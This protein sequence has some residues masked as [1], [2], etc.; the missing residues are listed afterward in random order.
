M[1][2]EN[3]E[4]QEE[5]TAKEKPKAKPKKKEVVANEFFSARE[6]RCK[7][8]GKDGFDADFLE[9]LTKIRIECDFP[10]AISSAYRDKSHP[11]EQ[12]KSGMGSH[13]MGKA[14]DVLC[15]GE[16]ALKLIE[17]AQKHG[18]K[19][20]GVQQRGLSR[21]IHIDSCTEADGKPPAIW[22]Y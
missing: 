1:T 7:H 2:E 19:R 11:A 20:I 10:F 18:I 4:V 16:K 5:V 6:L 21:F 22:S 13:S 9:L 17:V 15:R 3:K 14:V 12:G 8:T